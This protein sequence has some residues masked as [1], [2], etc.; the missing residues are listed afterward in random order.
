MCFWNSKVIIGFCEVGRK[1][2][3]VD[4]EGNG[5]CILK[6]LVEEMLSK[7]I[8]GGKKFDSSVLFKYELYKV[9]VYK[10]V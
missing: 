5:F 4:R 6:V 8:N 3:E 1:R 10:K 2:E 7:D 9:S